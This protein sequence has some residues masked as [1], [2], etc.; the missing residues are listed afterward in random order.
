MDLDA[1]RTNNLP[2]AEKAELMKANKCFYCRK[3]GHMAKDCYKKK[4]DRQGQASSSQGRTIE[5]HVPS[6]PPLKPFDTKSF[7]EALKEHGSKLDEETKLDII[8]M[9]MPQGFAQALD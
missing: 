3:V 4:H 6:T 7:G 1:T 8:E 5:E 2:E 9:L